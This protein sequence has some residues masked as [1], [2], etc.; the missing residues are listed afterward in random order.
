MIPEKSSLKDI[1]VLSCI[2]SFIYFIFLGLYPLFNPD[3]ARY[4]E[5]AREMVETRQ[6]IVPHLNYILYFEKPILF[7]W[8]LAS[9]IKVFGLSEWSIRFWTASFGI[10]GC[11]MTYGTARQLYNRRTALYASFILASS[12]LY[13]MM[14]HLVT[15][16]MPLSIFLTAS[17][18]CILL[19]LQKE[20]P[21]RR[22]Y[23]I[24]AAVFS[25]LALLTK[26]LIGILFPLLIVGCWMLLLNQWKKLKTWPWT[27]ALVIF[28]LIALPW[29][30]LI[31][32]KHPEFF[33]F[34]FIT[35]HLM[36][37]STLDAD[38][39]EPM[40]F[41]G[42]V[43]L[44]GFLPWTTF[45]FQSL[46]SSLSS[47]KNKNK[48][49]IN[50]FFILWIAIIFIFFTFSESKLIP[51]ILP[52]FPPLAMLLGNY[53]AQA[54]NNAGIGLKIG[55]TLVP[56]IGLGIIL[57]F[58]KLPNEYDIANPLLASKFSIILSIIFLSVS[59]SAPVLFWLKHPRAAFY[60]L[61]FGFLAG[62]L[63]ILPAIPAIDHN[64]I[65]P[66]ALT[67]KK[68]IRPGD[69]IINYNRYNQDLPFYLRRKITV[70]NWFTN[71]LAFGI[72]HQPHT[73]WMIT[74]QEFWKRWQASQRIFVI[75]RLDDLNEILENNPHFHY[76]L[77]AKTQRNVLFRN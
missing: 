66:L 77:I 29:H 36:R 2:F 17:L 71:E 60:I 67:L 30:I 19:S 62:F 34:Y 70:V 37:Y 47:W 39:Y 73:H 59:C 14:A 13:F 44:A 18:Y 35:Q 74:T 45:L 76:V 26:G 56:F 43:L 40:Y 42:M 46:G 25:A 55:W 23:F 31:Q 61:C 6:Y 7:Y 1:L 68:I 9:A 8:F 32:L 12:F 27:T 5:I 16:D 50:L 24:G 58:I 10:L 22:R 53:L 21:S 65:K 49:S 38:R 20:S 57:F 51:Y 48:F 75:T 41:F 72:A 33:H 11:L 63:L 54:E 3:E 4:A 28:L 52:I 69:E 15:L 64:S